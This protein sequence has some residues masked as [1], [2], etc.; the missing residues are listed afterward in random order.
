[1]SSVRTQA[2]LTR[3]EAMRILNAHA[4]EIRAQ[5]IVRLALFG[6]TA[7]GEA[8]PDSDV[9]LLV[10]YDESRNLSLLDI[11]GIS[12]RIEELL[13]RAVEFA[14]RKRLK[15]FL[16]DN[17]LAEAVE[18]FP[19]PGHRQPRPEGSPMPPRSPRQR[20]QDI[21][22]AILFVERYVAGRSLD[23]Y[24]R[25]DM[26]RAAVERKIEI[27]SEATRR[28]PDD[29]TAVHANIP[30]VK[31]RGVG[32]ILRHDYDEVYDEVVWNIAA[33]HIAPLKR[34]IEAMI[35]VVDRRDG[36]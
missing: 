36:R 20:L 9:D 18:I 22:D 8:R 33:Q 12:A 2:H 1:M 4:E 29:L 11:A 27:I 19:Q 10:D 14:D 16:K 24:R 32:N 28:L 13:G 6:S 30:W 21:L 3:D 5:G 35:A 7:R 26:L 25:D 17:I 31:I 34:A 23:D 15:P